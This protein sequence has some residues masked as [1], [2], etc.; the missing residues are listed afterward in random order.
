MLEITEFSSI[1]DLIN[2][3]P[4][5]QTCIEHLEAIRWN[6]VVVS[7][8]DSTSKVYKCR[9]GKYKCK[10]SA[11]YFNVRT[12][13]IFEDTK[14]SLQ[15]WIMAI[16]LIASHKKGISS[17]QLGRDLGVTQKTAWFLLH[18]VRYAFDHTNFQKE[19]SNIVEADETYVGGK[20]K[21]KHNN[22]KTG[23]TQGRSTKNK[24]VVLGLLERNENVKA[25]KV[26]DAKAET[27]QPI[28]FNN[29]K[30]DSK[31]MTDEWWGYRGLNGIYEQ[32]IVR[33][34]NNQYVDGVCHT[35]SIVG[36]WSLFKRGI[37][38]IYHYVSK[39]HIQQY[40]FEFTFRYNTRESNNSTRFN[41][42]LTS[43]NRRLKYK[44]LIA[45]E[46]SN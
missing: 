10:N 38:E 17:H 23:N 11:K 40:L 31:L 45:N 27:I 34:S 12:G 20:D 16:F 3:F 37:I 25:M 6:G 30:L 14:I 8:F 15:K 28:I 46:Q 7:P 43:I 41:F 9:G 24:P 5:E 35:N 39:K 2:K 13:T 1:I 36:F 32:S 33:H 4:N 42:Y 19:L 26:E 22:K 29:V 44:Q 18:R 21:N